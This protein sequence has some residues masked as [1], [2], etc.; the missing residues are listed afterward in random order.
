M[1]L[2]RFT[3]VAFLLCFIVVLVNSN[4]FKFFL[5]FDIFALAL[6]AGSA[7]LEY[8]FIRKGF[9]IPFKIGFYITIV[10]FVMYFVFSAN[11]YLKP[12]RDFFCNT[13]VRILSR[14]SEWNGLMVKYNTTYIYFYM[15][16]ILMQIV[17]G[18]YT[19]IIYKKKALST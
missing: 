9:K 2:L 5:P 14:G 10:L 13:H 18:I 17:T 3:L 11:V 7:L 15:L 12:S 19:I 8:L 6:M 16:A 1:T 4:E